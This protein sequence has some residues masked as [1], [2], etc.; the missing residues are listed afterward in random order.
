[1]PRSGSTWKTASGRSSG[2]RT[3][4]ASSACGNAAEAVDRG[5]VVGDVAI[6]VV[7]ERPAQTPAAPV[8]D[9]LL[10]RVDAAPD[11]PVAPKESEPV[12]GVP[13]AAPPPAPEVVHQARHV[14]AV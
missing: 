13:T 3:S 8:Q 2:S 9:H 10:V 5:D 12:I 7:E 1:M 14:I 6:R 11:D 4:R